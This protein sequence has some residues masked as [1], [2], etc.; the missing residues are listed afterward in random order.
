MQFALKLKFDAQGIQ[1]Q[2][3]LR[4]LLGVDPPLCLTLL[5]TPP[6]PF[7]PVLSC[8]CPPPPA[9]PPP[10]GVTQGAPKLYCTCPFADTF[11]KQFALFIFILFPFMLSNF[12]YFQ[13][14]ETFYLFF[15]SQPADRPNYRYVNNFPPVNFTHL[16]IPIIVLVNFETPLHLGH[17]YCIQGLVGEA[18]GTLRS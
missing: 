13:L 7:I 16:F 4:M 17:S 11:L 14:P 1:N 5:R 9:P 10:I 12:R 18:D 6:P 2:M 15:S 3:C 8:Y